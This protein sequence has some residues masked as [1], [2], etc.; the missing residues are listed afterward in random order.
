MSFLI[1]R[2]LSNSIGPYCIEVG[3]VSD[4]LTQS[5]YALLPF[6]GANSGY[7]LKVVTLIN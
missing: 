1:G 3:E 7:T 2:S 5:I 6:I 4:P